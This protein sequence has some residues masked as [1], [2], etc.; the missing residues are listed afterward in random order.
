M[1]SCA[2][3]LA[4][5][6]LRPSITYTHLLEELQIGMHCAVSLVSPPLPP[7]LPPR[8]TI[9]VH[10]R[11]SGLRL[12]DP[13]IHPDCEPVSS[14]SRSEHL[15]HFRQSVRLGRSGKRPGK[16]QHEC[17]RY[18][19]SIDSCLWVAPG[20]LR[21][22]IPTDCHEESHRDRHQDRRKN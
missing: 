20:A 12:S 4:E 7:C 15:P 14:G 5:R 2:C 22:S 8:T 11:P 21:L 6:L 3:G 13:R 9:L 19:C 16:A 18:I 1:Y 10:L 17:P